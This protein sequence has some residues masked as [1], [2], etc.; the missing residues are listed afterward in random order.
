M[1]PALDSPV[2]LM[3]IL[4]I[5]AISYAKKIIIGYANWLTQNP[6]ASSG[7]YLFASSTLALASG[8]GL[9]VERLAH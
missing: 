7:L 8:L 5:Y 2:L 6:G 1:E 4:T 3:L 9:S